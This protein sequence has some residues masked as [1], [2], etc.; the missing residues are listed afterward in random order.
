MRKGFIVKE[1][2]GLYGVYDG[3]NIINCRARGKFRIGTYSPMVG[4]NVLF[5][6]T[7]NYLMEIEERT[8]EML[9]PSLSNVETIAIVASV[10]HP[11]ILLSLISR[12]IVLSEMIYIKPLILLS[13]CDLC[14]DNY[15]NE[16][17]E[18]IKR[19]GYEVI[20]FSSKTLEGIEKIKQYIKGKRIVFAGQSGVG[21][22][23]LINNLI[24]GS[25]QQTQ[26][27]S[28]ALNRGK[29]TTRIVEYLKGEDYWIADTPGFSNIE[30]DLTALDVA[31]FYPG[32]NKYYGKCKFRD[33]IHEHE[34]GCAVKEA[35]NNHEIEEELYNDYL[36]LINDIK[37]R[38]TY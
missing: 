33:C 2:S 10:E 17:E 22:S 21:K 6:E 20:Q 30:F 36:K 24:P 11:R 3:T 15:A 18:S 16:L 8:N 7:N 26:E 4:D 32:F 25:K 12:Y 28:D 29:H 13:K 1:N 38:R 9:R 27:I 31:K 23:N 34:T 37:N 5:D 19:M 14:T 35:I